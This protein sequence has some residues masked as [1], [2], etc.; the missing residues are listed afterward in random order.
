MLVF[1]AIFAVLTA[2][3]FTALGC[4]SAQLSNWLSRRPK[5][6]AAVN[7]G[8]GLTFVAA[9]LSILTLGRAK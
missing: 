9:S 7:V 8:A 6:V 5:V 1:G 2:A 3:T 4:F